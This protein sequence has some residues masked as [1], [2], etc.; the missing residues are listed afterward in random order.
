ML[1]NWCGCHFGCHEWRVSNYTSG[2]G[3]IDADC[4]CCVLRNEPKCMVI[5]VHVRKVTQHW[6]KMLGG[7]SNETIL[8]Y[9]I[10]CP[11]YKTA[12]WLPR[13]IPTLNFLDYTLTFRCLANSLADTHWPLNS[14]ACLFSSTARLADDVTI[15]NR[16]VCGLTGLCF[17]TRLAHFGMQDFR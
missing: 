13:P 7:F 1:C 15:S 2:Y 6:T 5:E 10:T 4:L 14:V 9:K 12:R 17:F 3:T 11:P 8:W 16:H